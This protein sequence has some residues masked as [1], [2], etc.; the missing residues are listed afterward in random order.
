MWDFLEC[1]FS[2]IMSS[3]QHILLCRVVGNS[4]REVNS[5]HPLLFSGEEGLHF[6][7]GMHGLL[8]LLNLRT[9]QAL[10]SAE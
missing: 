10:F 2:I 5:G 6:E 8:L 7:L 1:H 4:G 9:K 3:F